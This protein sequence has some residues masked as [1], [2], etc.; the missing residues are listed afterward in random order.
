MTL[1]TVFQQNL[2]PISGILASASITEANDTLA[3][4]ASLAIKAS[5]SITEGADTLTASGVA[6]AS[7]VFGVLAATEDGDTLTAAGIGPYV[8]A[9]TARVNFGAF[10]GPGAGVSIRVAHRF[11]G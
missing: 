6:S 2:A 9:S 8:P 3:S 7:P 1:L 5:A 4:S 11:R 10:R